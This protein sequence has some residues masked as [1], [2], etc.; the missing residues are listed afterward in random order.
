MICLLDDDT[1]FFDIDVGVL[2][3]NALASLFLFMPKSDIIS[4]SWFN[5]IKWFQIKIRLTENI[6][7]QV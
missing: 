6:P 5:E 7:R 4:V 2:Q 3:G 1:D